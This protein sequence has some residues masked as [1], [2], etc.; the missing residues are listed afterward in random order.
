M[1]NRTT[2]QLHPLNKQPT[3]QIANPSTTGSVKFANAP[4]KSN[5]ASILLKTVISLVAIIVTAVTVPSLFVNFN[6]T[7]IEC[8]TPVSASLCETAI[9]EA[10]VSENNIPKPV[11]TSEYYDFESPVPER[12]PVSF[13]YFNETVFIGDSRTKGLILL[14]DIKPNY[15]FSAS[16]LNV[17][18]LNSK[19]YIRMEDE[20]TN[21]LHEYTVFEALQRESGN[22]NAVY[23]ATGL[24]ELGWSP[25]GY[26]AAFDTFV[27]NVRAVTDVPIYVQLVIPV[28]QRSSRTTLYG[29]TNEKCFIFNRLIRDY[30]AKNELFMLDPLSLFTLEDGTL[31]NEYTDDGIHLHRNACGILAEY[32]RTHVVDIYAYKNT[33]PT[34]STEQ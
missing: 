7:Y 34:E 30:V 2:E 19:A 27:K 28:T 17:G 29:I 20:E 31:S 3:V 32:Y 8:E 11:F 16:G 33:C 14:S 23:I 25:E 12:T 5:T 22:Y 15:D 1:K 18:S 10:L 21:E 13:N 26:M 24:N 4:Q 6:F 9:T